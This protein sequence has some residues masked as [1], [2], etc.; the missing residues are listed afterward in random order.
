MNI[1]RSNSKL[2]STSAQF[3]HHPKEVELCQF[4]YE[5]SLAS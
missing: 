4:A 5:I 2:N 1:Y 3:T